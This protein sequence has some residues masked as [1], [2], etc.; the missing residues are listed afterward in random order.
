[1]PAMTTGE[2]VRNNEK[3]WSKNVGKLGEIERSLDKVRRPDIY[4]PTVAGKAKG[5]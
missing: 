2:M 3:R 5:L 4:Y 1:M